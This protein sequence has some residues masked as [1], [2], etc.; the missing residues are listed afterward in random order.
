MPWMEKL[1]YFPG[2]MYM[3]PLCW[4]ICIASW[5][6]GKKGRRKLAGSRDIKKIMKNSSSSCPN[7]LDLAG[8]WRRRQILARDMLDLAHLPKAYFKFLRGWCH[9]FSREPK[10]D[11]RDFVVTRQQYR[12]SSRY[13]TGELS[14]SSTINLFL[15]GEKIGVF[16]L[17]WW[18]TTYVWV[19]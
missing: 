4:A 14:V 12:I 18:I 15:T 7:M 6:E 3:L 9:V 17:R 10:M 11:N 19:G 2:W 5:T 16:L 13:V 8:L 1:S